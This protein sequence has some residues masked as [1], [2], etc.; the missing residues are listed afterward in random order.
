[1][2]F[3]NRYHSLSNECIE[4]MDYRC[5]SYKD[6]S[7][8]YSQKIDKHRSHTD[9][10]VGRVYRSDILSV[11]IIKYRFIDKLLLKIDVCLSLTDEIIDRHV[12]QIL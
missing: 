9:V 8:N 10:T 11:K 4:L 12:S 7:I 6:L 2:S 5:K 3:S 1:M